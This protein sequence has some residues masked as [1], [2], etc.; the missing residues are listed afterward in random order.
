MTLNTLL[1]IIPIA[2]FFTLY[3]LYSQRWSLK[4]KH[5]PVEVLRLGFSPYI[6]TPVQRGLS[7]KG[8]YTKNFNYTQRVFTYSFLSVLDIGAPTNRYQ[9]SSSDK[10]KVTNYRFD[11]GALLGLH[12]V[13]NIRSRFYFQGGFSY[14]AFSYTDKSTLYEDVS[15]S[16]VVS[17]FVTGMEV[18]PF[19]L[20]GYYFHIEYMQRKVF[21]GDP[22]LD[23]DKSH[24]LNT[25]RFY[26][27]VGINFNFKKTWRNF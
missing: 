16:G 25:E 11:V 18:A 19:W 21:L 2:V 23:S 3:P 26:A 27:G 6:D 4:D 8:D 5:S 12:L 17:T 22:L 7:L 13:T 20:K 14:A 9:P 1:K 24:N 10:D 15:Y